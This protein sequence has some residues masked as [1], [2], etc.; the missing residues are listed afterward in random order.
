MNPYLQRAARILS[1]PEQTI[2]AKNIAIELLRN[3]GF[4]QQDICA[5][6]NENA[7]RATQ[8]KCVFLA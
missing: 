6:R 5:F 3:A 4:S 8:E 2:T 7:D 1:G